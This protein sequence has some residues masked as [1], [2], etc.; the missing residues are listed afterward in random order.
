MVDILYL[1]LSEQLELLYSKKI[2][3]EELITKSIAHI[4]NNNNLNALITLCEEESFI[5]AKKQDENIAKKVKKPLSGIP[6]ILK[7]NICTKN[8]RTTA[9]CKLLENYFPPYNA[10]VT[11]KLIEAG[12]VILGKANMDE[13]AMGSSTENS[14]FGP[15]LNP[16]DNDRIPGG[17]SGG[18]A[19]SVAC[20]FSSA[21]LG[22]DTGGSIRQPAAMTGV[23]GLKPTYGRV[24]R[25]GLIAYGSSLDQIGPIGRS[26]EDVYRVYKIISGYDSKDTTSFQDLSNIGENSEKDAITSS[27]I[28]ELFGKPI[29]ELKIGIA[30]ECSYDSA[31][32]SIK[33]AMDDVLS[34]YKKKGSTIVDISLEHAPYWI[35]V[36]YLIA[37]AEASSNLSRFDGVRYGHRLESSTLEDL[38]VKTRNSGFGEE[39]KRRIMLGTFAL[40]SGYYDAYYGKA[41]SIRKFIQDD[42]KKAFDKCDIIIM[43]TSPVPAFKFKEK[44]DPLSMYLADIYTVG[45]NLAGIPAI[46][47]PCGFSAENLPI[48]VQL[49]AKRFNEDKLFHAAYHYEQAH[50]WKDKKPLSL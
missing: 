17:S 9:G 8:I 50:N 2:T 42:F 16:W 24:S 6:L 41:S 38:Y 19:V 28:K 4:K 15:V 3:S 40:S 31:D 21:A 44:S 26:V 37:T 7:D 35:A 5:Q 25:Y 36:Y 32:P 11:E 14:A 22:S 39:V 34:F 49:L 33:T 45:A 46:S 29:S 23:V 48:G 18:S 30:K 20:G 43:P 12:A 27:N 10:T 47:I 13:F 1:S